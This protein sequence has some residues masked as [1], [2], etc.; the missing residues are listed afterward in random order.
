MPKFRLS[1]IVIGP[2][3]ARTTNLAYTLAQGALSEVSMTL[4]PSGTRAQI[5][6]P[7]ISRLMNS[8]DTY[9]EAALTL[10]ISAYSCTLERICPPLIQQLYF[11]PILSLKT[12]LH[13]LKLHPQLANLP[14]KTPPINNP[15]HLPH[16]PPPL[17][18]KPHN[19]PPSCPLNPKRN[20]HPPMQ[21]IHLAPNPRHHIPKINLV[22]QLPLPNLARA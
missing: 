2:T 5:L 21:L 15:T 18:P 1:E 12:P 16:P 10:D 9:S 19:P 8:A 17:T 20:I 7:F 4:V 11:P 3:G 13:R 6:H 22:S 14:H